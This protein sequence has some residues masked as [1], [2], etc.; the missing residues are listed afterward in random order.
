MGAPLGM[1][2]GVWFTLFGVAV[3]GWCATEVR[4]RRSVR[5]GGARVMARVLADPDAGIAHPDTSPVLGFSVE[6]H[7]EVVTR[8][9]GWT[10]IGRTPLLPVDALVPVS[11][12]PA[13]PSVVVVEGVG[14]G[15]SDFFWIL[16]GLAFTVCGAALL[17]GALD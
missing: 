9:R 16:L 8:P 13:R 6:G 11:Y 7:G 4:T 3:L 1:F 10:S 12:D 5:R 17:S 15:R 2:T 14:Q